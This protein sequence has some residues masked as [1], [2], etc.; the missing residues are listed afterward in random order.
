MITF[1]YS[2]RFS[3]PLK[4]ICAIAF[5]VLMILT[6]ADAMALIVK[7]LAV[8]IFVF[9]V[10]SLATALAAHRQQSQLLLSNSI[11]NIVIALLLFAFAGTLSLIIRYVLGVILL[12]F[13][14]SQI[15]A[16]FSARHYLKGGIAAFILPVIVMFAGGLFFSKEL[17][18]ND[19]IGIIAGVAFIIYGISEIFASIKMRRAIS[20]MNEHYG[21]EVK[22]VEYTKVDDQTE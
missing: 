13:G 2:N 7:I 8:G 18:G 11:V 22:D 9:G 17:I 1:G 4:A 3:G 16:L 15:A 10:F 5:G 19:L 6:K 12:L 21:M 14:F 20:E